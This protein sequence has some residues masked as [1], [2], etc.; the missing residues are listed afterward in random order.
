MVQRA[1]PGVFFAF[2]TR[3]LFCWQTQPTAAFL[4]EKKKKH[5][6]DPEGKLYCD[7]PN[8][9]VFI[10]AEAYDIGIECSRC[11]CE[12]VLMLVREISWCWHTD[13]ALFAVLIRSKTTF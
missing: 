7:T 9:C 12:S 5:L 6:H 11:V 10:F 2:I 4:S 3:V 1:S 13:R 8:C